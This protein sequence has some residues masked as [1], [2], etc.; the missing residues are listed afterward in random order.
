MAGDDPA[1][2]VPTCDRCGKVAAV[3]GVMDTKTM[4]FVCFDCLTNVERSAFA[5]GE[6][7]FR[8]DED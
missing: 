3:G 5:R 8:K 4:R 7:P 2:L 6:S 1:P